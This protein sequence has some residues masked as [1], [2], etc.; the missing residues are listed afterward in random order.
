MAIQSP[1]LDDR[2][3]KDII[4]EAKRRIPRYAPEWTDWNESD[5]G[6]TLIQLFAWMSELIIYRLN[7]VPDKNFI[8]FLRLIGVDLKPAYPAKVDLTFTLS[9]GTGSAVIPMGTRVGLE[10]D[11]AEDPI[12]FETDEALVAVEAALKEIQVFDGS[13][14]KLYTN[15]NEV[16]GE[17]FDAFG[18]DAREDN[19]F[20]LGFD[21]AFPASEVK[22]TVYF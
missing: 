8:E 10:D 2:T 21:Q 5:P 20:Y 9:A 11:D 14:Y 13:I 16:V 22:L 1:N 17:D 19:A 6:I 7:Q 15:A 18:K 4:E 12:V 3:F